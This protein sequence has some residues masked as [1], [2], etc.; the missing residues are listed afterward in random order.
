[1]L[2]AGLVLAAA[3]GPR[4]VRPP[5]RADTTR[6]QLAAAGA[7][8]IVRIGTCTWPSPSRDYRGEGFSAGV[9]APGGTVTCAP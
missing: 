5:D 8:A 2:A 1:M 9:M 3:G 7:P 6:P 4:D